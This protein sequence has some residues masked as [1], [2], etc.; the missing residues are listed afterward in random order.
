MSLGDGIGR[1][2]GIAHWSYGR[3]R[4]YFTGAESFIKWLLS[5]E[6]YSA[7]MIDTDERGIV[8]A[9]DNFTVSI[10]EL[11]AEFKNSVS[12]KN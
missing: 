6:K 4:D 1:N 3:Q 9:K 2:K 11:L 12:Q 7:C 5:N 10:D 8:L